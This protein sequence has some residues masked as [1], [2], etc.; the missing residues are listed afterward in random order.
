MR[1]GRDRSTEKGDRSANRAKYRN[2]GTTSKTQG[3][4]L[5]ETN[6]SRRSGRGKRRT[7]HLSSVREIANSQPIRAWDRVPTHQR[8]ERKK[9]PNTGPL[10][11]FRA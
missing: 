10:A 11:V 5:A 8:G 6:S 3:E 7:G 1:E 9:V 2:E 4:I